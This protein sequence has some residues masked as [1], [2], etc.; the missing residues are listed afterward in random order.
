MVLYEKYLK[1][2]Y[3]FKPK[4]QIDLKKMAWSGKRGGGAPQNETC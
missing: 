2:N 4:Y 3:Q 1:E